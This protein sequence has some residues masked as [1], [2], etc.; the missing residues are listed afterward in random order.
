MAAGLQRGVLGV[1][2]GAPPLDIVGGSGFE[3][4]L[5][6][7]AQ[8]GSFNSAMMEG[9]IDVGID[10]QVLR[11]TLRVQ[12][13]EDEEYEGDLAVERM[14]DEGFH[15]IVRE[16]RG[17]GLTAGETVR[18][19]RLLARLTRQFCVR[20]K[21]ELLDL[22]MSLAQDRT[23]QPD[24]RSAA[25]HIAALNARIASDLGDPEMAYGRRLEEVQSQ[26]AEAVRRALE[27]GLTPDVEAFIREYLAA[28]AKD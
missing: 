19:L 15:W 20:R 24:V 8:V 21:G 3:L 26:V 13:S 7:G 16:V 2:R 12:P 4:I 11:E 9:V 25:A 18:A 28:A 22:T 5:R 17:G 23:A 10:V 14:G 6:G 27:V 1:A